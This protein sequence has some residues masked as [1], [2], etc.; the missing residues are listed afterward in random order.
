MKKYFWLSIILSVSFFPVLVSADG[1]MVIWPP[2]VHLDQSDQNA[3]VAWNGEKEIIILSNDIESSHPATVLR[4]VPLPSE[5]KIRKAGFE[6]FEKLIEIVNEKLAK[7]REELWTEEGL[8]DVMPGGRL[9]PGV[10]IVF[11]EKIGTHDLTVVKVKDSNQFLVWIENFA[12]EKKLDAKEISEEFKEGIESYLRKKINYFVFDI[13]EIENKKSIEPLVYE[14]NSNFLFYPLVI[15]GVS[16]ISESLAKIQVFLIT[17][18]SLKAP[19]WREFGWAVELNKEE[20]SQA[21]EEIARLFDLSVKVRTFNYQGE[22]KNLKK[23]L[24][25]FSPFGE[26][27]LYIGYQGEDVKLLQKILMNEGFWSS[28][29]EATGYFG[30]ITKAALIRY[31]EDKPSLLQQLGLKQGAGFFG[32]MT[33]Q[34]LN[35]NSLPIKTKKMEWQRNLYLGMEGD[36]VKRLQEILISEK[37]W[38]R[39][40]IGITGYFGTITREAVIKFQE[41]Y[42]S[43][44]LE[45][46]GLEK[47]TGFVGPLTRDYLEELQSLSKKE[48]G[49]SEEETRDYYG[50]STLGSCESPFDCYVSGCNSEICQSKFEEELLSMCILPDKPTPSQLGYRCKCFEKKCKWLK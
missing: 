23:D 44:I 45:P 33:R 34:S 31:Q 42:S 16:E 2:D 17:E 50:H 27:D 15:S 30:P 3:I 39:P 35:S 8:G 22:L 9:P 36:D 13:I 11:Q 14:F 4:I 40:E 48:V 6:T 26:R 47:G 20:L 12:K 7:I 49:I 43:K 28:E 25:I 29:D 21:S 46:V 32:K 18:D 37:V 10:E 1:G 24:M 5:P 38:P 41:K 19:L